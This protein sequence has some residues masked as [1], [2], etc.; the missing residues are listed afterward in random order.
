MSKPKIILHPSHDNHFQVVSDF[1]LS[2][3]VRSHQLWLSVGYF[4]NGAGCHSELKPWKDQEQLDTLLH[5]TGRD[6]VQAGEEK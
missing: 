5:E 6:P 4:V 3:K 1:L 2:K